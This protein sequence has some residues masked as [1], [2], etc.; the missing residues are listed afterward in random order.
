MRLNER[1]FELLVHRAGPRTSLD[2]IP[3]SSQ[4]Y[5]YAV[6]DEDLL[7]PAELR[8]LGVT[9]SAEISWKSQIGSMVAKG[10]SSATWVLSVFRSREPDVMMTLVQDICP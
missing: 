3:L 6:S 7:S 9:I 1:K 4:L 10:R 5:S 2:C 8:D